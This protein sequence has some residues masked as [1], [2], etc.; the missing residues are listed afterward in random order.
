LEGSVPARSLSQITAVE[1]SDYN[2]SN[3]PKISQMLQ[4]CTPS[5]RGSYDVRGDTLFTNPRKREENLHY[6]VF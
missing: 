3:A 6:F 4:F 2:F 1:E 5:L